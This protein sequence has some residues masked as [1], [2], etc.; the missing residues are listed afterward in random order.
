[1]VVGLGE[2]DRELDIG[3]VLIEDLI[4]GNRARAPF[5]FGTKRFCL[6]RQRTWLISFKA[7]TNFN[8]RIF[9]TGLETNVSALLD[10]CNVICVLRLFAA[11]VVE[12]S[13][14]KKSVFDR[15]SGFAAVI[16]KCRRQSEEPYC[17]LPRD[18]S[19]NKRD[20]GVVTIKYMYL[21]Y[22]RANLCYSTCNIV[23][24]SFHALPYFLYVFM[25]S[26]HG[27]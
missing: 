16:R 18:I 27:L 17:F 20:C 11:L 4:E 2:G 3:G 10:P 23:H 19:R 12:R 15:G 6:R 5:L 26:L 22:F 25:N 1:M 13:T 14:M 7:F 9:F 21:K 8:F 24:D